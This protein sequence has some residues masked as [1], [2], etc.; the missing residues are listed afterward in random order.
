MRGGLLLVALSLARTKPWDLDLG[1]EDMA[2]VSD[3]GWSL[4]RFIHDI[5]QT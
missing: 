4:T 5:M 2:E 3:M 1:V